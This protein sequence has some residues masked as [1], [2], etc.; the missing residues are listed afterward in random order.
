VAAEELLHHTI[1]GAPPHIVAHVSVIYLPLGDVAETFT[2]GT[3]YGT[4]AIWW[5]QHVVCKD[6]YSSYSA[7][8]HSCC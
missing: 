4:V 8:F 3:A 6:L 2:A 7:M 1:S 5:L